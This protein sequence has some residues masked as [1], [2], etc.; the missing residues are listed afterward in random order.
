VADRH[1]IE[2][3]DTAEKSLGEIVAEV[4]E[5]AALLVRE[6]VE[7]AKAEVQTKVTRLGKALAVGAAAGLF[8]L[9]A[10]YM[11]TFALGFFFVDLFNLEGIWTAF[12][13]GTA[14]WLVLAAIAGF[15]AY[16]FVKK[17]SPPTPE[18]AIEEAKLTRKAIDEARR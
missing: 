13:I 16:R 9:L 4:S 5:K 2:P 6:E 1:G 3:P 14:L 17:G 11:F 8:V 12:L 18:M 15:V 10:V 7:L